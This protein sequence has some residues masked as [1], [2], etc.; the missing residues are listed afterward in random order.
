MCPRAV[1]IYV[2][3]MSSPIWTHTHTLWR[4]PPF[5]PFQPHT[6]LHTNK[7]RKVP[8]SYCLPVFTNLRVEVSKIFSDLHIEKHEKHKGKMCC[9]IFSELH[10]G[11]HKKQEG[12]MFCKIFSDLQRETHEK[13]KGENVF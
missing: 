13:H 1:W 11:K 12:K 6:P 5:T 4:T 9:K 7:N 10:I 3:Y 2:E 8:H